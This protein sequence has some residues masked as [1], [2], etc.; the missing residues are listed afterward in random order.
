LS[1]IETHLKNKK[2]RVRKGRGEERRVGK[3]MGGEGLTE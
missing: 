3:E 1:Y 2:G